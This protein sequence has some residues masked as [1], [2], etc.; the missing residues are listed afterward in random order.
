MY[1][2]YE[3]IFSTANIYTKMM[4][5]EEV[6]RELAKNKTRK[7][8]RNMLRVLYGKKK[9]RGHIKE[10]YK[11]LYKNKKELYS[12]IMSGFKNFV[13]NKYFNI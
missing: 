3:S 11:K 7:Q 9:D 1:N 10:K 6:I 5:D 4:L 2:F 13:S 12:A 8:F